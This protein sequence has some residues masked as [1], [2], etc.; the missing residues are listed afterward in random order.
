M[1]V[2]RVA[3]LVCACWLANHGSV[4]QI[5]A[6]R[7]LKTNWIG[8]CLSLQSVLP[9]FTECGRRGLR[10]MKLNDSGRE[11]RVSNSRK[12][13]QQAPH[14]HARTERAFKVFMGC[15]KE[16]SVCVCV[17]VCG[18]ARVRCVWRDGGWRWQPL[19]ACGWYFVR[20]EKCDELL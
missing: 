10:K 20:S 9:W 17:C 7:S 15:K 14:V 12:P 8:V 3:C 5:S 13:C 18:S 1:A 11:K 16:K 19:Y 6:T 4:A 2:E